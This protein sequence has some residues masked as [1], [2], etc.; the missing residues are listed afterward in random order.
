MPVTGQARDEGVAVSA[1]HRS[2]TGRKDRRDGDH[3][4]PV[5]A[6]AEFV[7]QVTEPAETVRLVY[8]DHAPVSGLAR[9]VENGRDLRGMVAVIVNDGDPVHL[10]HLGE[11]SVYA[12]EAGHRPSD[13]VPRHAKVSGHGN[14]RERV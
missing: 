10:P 11:P 8:G 5:E 3:V 9:R 1:L 14:R 4:G 13:P 7:E 12:L 2:L 6:G